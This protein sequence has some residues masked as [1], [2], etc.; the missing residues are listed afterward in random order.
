MRF[1]GG[2]TAKVNEVTTEQE[3]RGMRRRVSGTDAILAREVLTLALLTI[4]PEGRS[5]RQVFTALMPELYVLRMRGCGFNQIT[6]LLN[7]CGFTL[8][9]S[10]VRSYYRTMLASEMKLCEKRMEKQLLMRAKVEELK[11]A[12]NFATMAAKIVE[13]KTKQ[14]AVVVAKQVQP[15]ETQRVA[16]RL[17][18]PGEV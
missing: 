2:R 10:T 1:S 18:R 8:Q 9:P 17:I 12:E 4:E 5:Q 16:T 11:G 3:G 6:T 7:A 15:A 13:M 14:R